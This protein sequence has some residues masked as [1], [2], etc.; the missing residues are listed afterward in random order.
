MGNNKGHHELSIHLHF[1]A[2]VTH[3]YRMEMPNPTSSM[4][5]GELRADI[6]VVRYDRHC[7]KLNDKFYRRISLIVL[8]NRR[9]DRQPSCS[10]WMHHIL[11]FAKTELR[12]QANLTRLYTCPCLPELLRRRWPPNPSLPQR[13]PQKRRLG[14][15]VFRPGLQ[16]RLLPLC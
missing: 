12:L 11:R 6:S 15:S 9:Y 10:S 13:L 16:C 7:H 1:K 2:K 4:F 5:S 3:E 8:M 14:S